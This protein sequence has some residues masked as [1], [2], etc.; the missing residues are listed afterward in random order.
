MD[1]VSKLAIGGSIEVTPGTGA[2]AGAHTCNNEGILSSR[3]VNPTGRFSDRVAD[4]VRA[5]PGYPRGLIPLLQD[6]TGLESAW[7]VADIGSGTG[8]SARPFLAFGNVVFGVE[9]NDEM[10]AAG[11]QVLH[12]YPRFHSIAGSAEQT[13]LE[14]QSIDLIIAGQAFHW[15]DRVRA[16]A[17][18]ARILK[19][20]GWIALFW[21]RRDTTGSAFARDYEALL[22]RFGTDYQQVRHDNLGDSELGSFLG[23]T[24]ERAALPNE[25]VLDYEGLQGRLLSSSYTPPAGDERRAA[26]LEELR[27]LFDRH[28]QK[29]CVTIDYATEIFLAR[30]ATFRRQSAAHGG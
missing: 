24:Y 15:F 23:M 29:G 25:Q 14:T 8:L 11:E 9:P 2:E 22:E 5:R 30:S 17:E 7:V 4:Y 12:N 26:M 13:T 16:R 28:Q 20:D 6:R 3:R 27:E 19:P 18:F 21:N 1:R 10:R